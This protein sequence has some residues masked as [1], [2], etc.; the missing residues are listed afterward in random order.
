[1]KV[2]LLFVILLLTSPGIWQV[3]FH[4]PAMLSEWKDLPSN[5]VRNLA[6]KKTS[7]YMTHVSEL[8]WGGRNLHRDSLFAKVLYNR[9]LFVANELFDW[10]QFATPKLYFLA[11]D[12]SSFSPRRIEPISTLLFPF[13]V[14]GV[15]YLLAQ[16]N[17]KFWLIFLLFVTLGYL[18]GRKNL[19]ILLPV[20]VLNVYLGYIGLI[21]LARNKR[22]SWLVGLV[23]VYGVYI[24]AMNIWLNG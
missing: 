17:Y 6:S 3:F 19:A 20:M 13:W 1:M 15:I 9:P 7:D 24:T 16:R 10:A 21:S 18:S 2:K 4:T 23:I 5:I 14:M 8:R 11:G 22:Y 12:G